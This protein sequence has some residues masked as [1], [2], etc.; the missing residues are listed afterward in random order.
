MLNEVQAMVVVLI[1]LLIN[2]AV[3]G[4]VILHTIKTA[5]KESLSLAAQLLFKKEEKS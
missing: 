2:V 4:A 1:A 3:Y 5:R